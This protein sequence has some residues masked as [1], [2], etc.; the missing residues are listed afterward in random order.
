MQIHD[1]LYQASHHLIMDHFPIFKSLPNK[2]ILDCSKLKQIADDILK[3][4]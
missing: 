2:K 4:I 1:A 3:C